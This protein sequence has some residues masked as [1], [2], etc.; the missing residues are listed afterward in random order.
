M[1][2]LYYILLVM[3]CVLSLISCG[4]TEEYE[5]ALITDYGT[6]TDQSFN[7]AT[8]EAIKS[9]AESNGKTYSRK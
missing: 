6:I 9:Y 4:N 3:F 5:I 7:Q 1:K 2:K 8:W